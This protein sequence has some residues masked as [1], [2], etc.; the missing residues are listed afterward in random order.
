MDDFNFLLEPTVIDHIKDQEDK[1]VGPNLNGLVKMTPK[2]FASSVLEVYRKLGGAS[3]LLIEAKANPR[4]FLELLKK[5]I[6]TG[7][8][9]EDLHGFSIRLIDQFGNQIVLDKPVLDKPVLEAH[10]GVPAISPPPAAG[11]DPDSQLSSVSLNGPGQPEIATSGN[12]QD[13]EAELCN[14][15]K[16]K[17]IFE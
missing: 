7:I 1:Y 15:V 6:P 9:M 8:Q 17:E 16:I 14:K 10:G 13:S 11:G 3:W 5:M 2:Q 4:A 12:P